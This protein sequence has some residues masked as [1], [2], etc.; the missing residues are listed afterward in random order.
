[1]SERQLG[2]ID[3]A[4]LSRAISR[5]HVPVSDL[6]MCCHCVVGLVGWLVIQFSRPLI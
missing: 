4:V 6:G 3:S 1:M 5:V 2:S